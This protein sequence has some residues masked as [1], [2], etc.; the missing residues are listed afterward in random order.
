MTA[1]KRTPHLAWVHTGRA[2]TFL[3]MGEH[4]KALADVQR[5]L[6]MFPRNAGA[7][8]LRARVYE[9]MTRPRS[10][11]P[12]R[13]H[14]QRSRTKP[15]ALAADKTLLVPVKAECPRLVRPKCPKHYAAACTQHG[16]GVMARCCV[17]MGC[18]PRP[19]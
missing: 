3:A 7:L 5:S 2:R 15:A 10:P 8:N 16:R 19:W 6:A 13:S 17:R 1:I 14:C 11:R 4:E 12:L 18:V 9:A